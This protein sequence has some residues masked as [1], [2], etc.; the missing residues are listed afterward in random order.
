MGMGVIRG[1]SFINFGHI[2]MLTDNEEITVVLSQV[3]I[4]IQIYKS[5]DMAFDPKG[6]N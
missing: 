2:A 6:G 5:A 1:I 3:P 4:I